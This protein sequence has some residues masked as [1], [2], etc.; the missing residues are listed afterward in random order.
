MRLV[1]GRWYWRAT[2]KATRAVLERLAP[3]KQNIA[4]G[5]SNTVADAARKWWAA[6]VLP[7]I[8]TAVP[9]QLA[10]HGTVQ[11]ILDRAKLEIVPTYS[12]KTQDEWERYITNL[13]ARFGK[14]RYAKSEAEAA[15]GNFLRSMHLTQYLDEQANADRPVAGNKEVQALSRMFHKA[16]SR[17]G[18][19]E[20]NPCLQVEYNDEAPRLVYQSDEN[21]LKFYAKA[22]PLGQV[23]LDLAQVAGPRRG[24]ILKLNLADIKPEGVLLTLNKK[25]RTDAPRHQLVRWTDAGGKDTGLREIIDRAMALRRQ[26]RGGQ[27]VVADLTTAPLFLNRRGKR[28]T[29]TG[30]NSM[31]QRAGRAAGFKAHEFHP[32]DVRVKSLSDSP[33]AA[34]AQDRGGHL[35]GRTTRGTYRAKPIEVTPLKRVSKNTT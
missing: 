34:D 12:P 16:K 29:E 4:A 2:D 7:A 31:M 26:V 18:Y 24:M 15:S 21:F 3:G 25:K 9:D 22:P 28:V 27:K 19:T 14:W 17:W 6:N 5:P 13:G 11:E 30:Y 1:D 33:S 20:Y 32:H 35:D 10:T 8:T 23:M